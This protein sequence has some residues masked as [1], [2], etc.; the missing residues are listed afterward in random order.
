MGRGVG[1][2]CVKLGRDLGQETRLLWRFLVG[3]MGGTDFVVRRLG[4]GN[5]IKRY[6]K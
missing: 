1:Y 6:L 4:E 5:E 2:Q 3:S